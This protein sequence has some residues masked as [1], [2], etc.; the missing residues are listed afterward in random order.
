M[1][2]DAAAAFAI[3]RASLLWRV[4]TPLVVAVEVADDFLFRPNGPLWWRVDTSHGLPPPA[5]PLLAG[6]A[7][8]E[9]DADSEGEAETGARE[10][11]DVEAAEE[12]EAE[13]SGADKPGA[14]MGDEETGEVEA[15]DVLELEEE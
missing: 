2:S 13:A 6:S 9:A 1:A 10:V 12:D 14:V 4:P 8:E 15:G 3:A 7:E 11:A 5:L